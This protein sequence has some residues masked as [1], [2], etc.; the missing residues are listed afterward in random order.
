MNKIIRTIALTLVLSVSTLLAG[1]GHNH[2]H[3]KIDETKVKKIAKSMIK[4][5]SKKGIIPKSWQNK[6]IKNIQKKYFGK[7]KEWVVSLSNDEIKD[8]SKQNLYVF[9]SEYGKA[10]AVNYTGK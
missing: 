7:K 5:L 3:S 2:S 8:K 1:L 6:E 4:G 10:I 9:I